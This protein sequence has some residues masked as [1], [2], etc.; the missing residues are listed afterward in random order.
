MGLARG[1][2]I[3]ETS[4][5]MHRPER[6]RN[7]KLPATES[8]G[9]SPLERQGQRL[10]ASSVKASIQAPVKRLAKSLASTAQKESLK[11]ENRSKDSKR[12][13]DLNDTGPDKNLQ[14]KDAQQKAKPADLHGRQ[15]RIPNIPLIKNSKAARVTFTLLLV[16][17]WVLVAG[18]W[19][20]S[21]LGSAIA[22]KG[23]I[24]PSALLQALPEAIVEAPPVATSSIISVAEDGADSGETPTENA[25]AAPPAEGDASSGFPVGMAIVLSGTCAAG[26]LL[27]SRRRRAMARLSAARSKPRVRRKPV[28][29]DVV[30]PIETAQG[31]KQVRKTASSTASGKTARVRAANLRSSNLRTVGAEDAR[32][33]SRAK[34]R[35]QR[36]K[37]VAS[38][39]GAQTVAIKN[40]KKGQ[41]PTRKAAGQKAVSRSVATARGPR[42]TAEARA[43]RVKR[44]S[45]RMAHR[46]S[47]VSVVPAGESHALDWTNGSLAHQ[48]DVRQPRTASM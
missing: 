42:T 39:S 20:V 45:S 6:V 18:L 17:P 32:G 10:S 3:R 37:R 22:I 14:N 33:T 5:T 11:P 34:K 25:E 36:N 16:R 13:S 40:R 4:S 30:R 28:R 38:V 43:H 46:Q 8:K 29:T 47:V 9:D 26:C 19:M 35:R 27:M 44:A 12:N 15:S 2:T 23:L 24:R 21:L 31:L 48:M 1:S 41:L 7:M